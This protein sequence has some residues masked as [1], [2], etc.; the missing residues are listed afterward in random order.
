MT[1]NRLEPIGKLCALLYKKCLNLN[2]EG[3]RSITIG[4]GCSDH[5]KT[6]SD[7]TI[8]R[9]AVRI[10]LMI[11]KIVNIMSVDVNRCD[12][13]LLPF[14][15]ISVSPI[16]LAIAIWQIYVRMGNAIWGALG[17]TVFFLLLNIGQVRGSQF[18]WLQVKIS[19]LIFA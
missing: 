16:L 9:L 14:S 3:R 13:I 15:Q 19:Q 12:R 5:F 10:F 7:L 2:A 8:Y 18:W 17:T 11:G 4:K 6:V 1:L